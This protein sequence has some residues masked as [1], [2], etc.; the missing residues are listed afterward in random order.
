MLFLFAVIYG[1]AHGGIFTVVSPTVAE[2]FGTGS[3]GVL[4]GI[5]LFSGN[6]GAA[7]GPFLAGRMFDV[8]GS[9]R[10]VFLAL[11]GMALLALVLV[12]LLRPLRRT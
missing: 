2:L 12:A 4:F 7:A 9:Y 11:T 8:T 6:I 3:H 10:I 1:F 5:V